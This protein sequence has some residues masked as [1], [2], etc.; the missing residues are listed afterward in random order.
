MPIEKHPNPYSIEWIKFAEK[1]QVTERCKVS[2]SIGRYKDEVYCDM[3]DINACHLLFRRP[4]QYDINVQYVGR[5]NIYRVEKGGTKFTLMLI[6]E[7]SHLNTL[8]VEGRTFF[9]LTRSKCE[10]EHAYKE[11]KEVHA[12]IVK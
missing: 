10:M 4:W 9:T 6:K 2:F 7:S 5:E 12:L 11:A 1:I 8:K 3:V